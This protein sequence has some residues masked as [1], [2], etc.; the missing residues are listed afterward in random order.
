[1]ASRAFAKAYAIDRGAGLL[2]SVVA[3]V[4]GVE[5]ARVSKVALGDL[6]VVDHEEP[7]PEGR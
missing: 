2:S 4:P 5:E 7:V 1:M 6:V 3:V